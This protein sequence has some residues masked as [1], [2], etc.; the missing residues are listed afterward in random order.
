MTTT[1]TRRFEAC[2]WRTLTPRRHE[3]LRKA[4]KLGATHVEPVDPLVVL[5]LHDGVCGI[6]GGDVDP[7]DYHVDHI[8]PLSKGGFHNL[9]NSQPAHPSC[10]MRKGSKLAPEVS[11]I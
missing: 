7:F 5:E 10:N 6:C 8:V 3:A 2:R 11:I 9:A 4:R 1:G